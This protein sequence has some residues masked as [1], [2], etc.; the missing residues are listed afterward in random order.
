VTPEPADGDRPEVAREHPPIID[1]GR[2]ARRLRLMISVIMVLVAG[3]WL[4]LG[5]IGD[6]LRLQ[7]LA[8]LIGFGLLAAF[9]AEVVVVGGSAVRGLLD[10]GARGER[11]ASPDVSLLPPQLHRRRG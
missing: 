10:A 3:S 5:L 8:E 1:W 9:G 2:T 11:L 4:A 6:G 7:L